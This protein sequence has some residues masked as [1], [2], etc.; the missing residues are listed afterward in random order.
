[1]L[2]PKV[3]FF[4]RL[5][6]RFR[7]PRRVLPTRAGM[8]TLMAPLVLG[9][10]AINASNN[11]LF[12][13]V[14][15]CLGLITLS[16]IV[17]ERLVRV[18][19]VKVSPAG[20]VRAREVSRLVVTAERPVS[21]SPIFDLRIRERTRKK[22]QK[23]TPMAERLDAR[24]PVM[25]AQ[26]SSVIGERVFPK[27]GL[28]ALKPLEL[29]TRYPFG[30]LTKACDLST[31][32]E[33]LVRPAT[34]DVPARL[35][36]PRGLADQGRPAARRGAG[37]DFYGLREREDRDL[38][39]RVHA[40]RSMR[41]GHE[42]VLETEATARP[43]AWIGVAGGA[44]T[45]PEAFERALELAQASIEAWDAQGWAVGLRAPGI[46]LSPERATLPSL[47]DTLAL[48]SIGTEPAALSEGAVWLVPQGAQVIDD[49]AT[50]VFD[51][52]SNGALGERAQRRAA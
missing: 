33:V 13:L 4:E 26:A 5:A 20:P 48:L 29:L 21:G 34:V 8:V 52:A 2:E 47:L 14:G 12:L 24:I 6:I 38:D 36:D 23:L 25:D 27:R 10:A 41:L 31:T 15:A 11:L 30:L 39:A 46:E 37:D 22:M 44:G 32:C 40:L 49:G 28:A 9:V 16:G 17:S 51:V 43:V 19:E 50:A 45:D 35:A 1:M 18:V 42:V 3:G 7:P